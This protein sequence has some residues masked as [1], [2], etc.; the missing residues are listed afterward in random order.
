MNSLKI[1]IIA[2]FVEAPSLNLISKKLL[3]K[4]KNLFKM[5]K[6]NKEVIEKIYKENFS[7][8]HLEFNKIQSYFLNLSTGL[9]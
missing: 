9:K 4:L 5:M 3:F 1:S 8:V 6:L 2:I 7:N